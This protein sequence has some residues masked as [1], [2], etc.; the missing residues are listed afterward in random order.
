MA[1]KN[2]CK[3]P[4]GTTKK[5]GYVVEIQRYTSAYQNADNSRICAKFYGRITSENGDVVESPDAGWAVGDI[6]K[7]VGNTEK[8]VYNRGGG[9]GESQEI[10]KLR[11][12]IAT[13][14]SAGLPTDEAESKLNEL[15]AQEEKNRELRKAEMEA[16]R[17]ARKAAS[18]ANRAKKKE[19]NKAIKAIKASIETMQAMGLDTI[20]LQTLL[21]AKQS[22]LDNI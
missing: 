20:A 6:D 21:D 2:Q 22:E 3:Y 8:R 9:T 10:R 15:I 1:K 16:E 14:E 18:E 12:A 5:N 13:L 4:V 11:T 7:I 19:L 17:V